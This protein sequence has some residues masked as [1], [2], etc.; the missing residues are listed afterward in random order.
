MTSPEL[1]PDS[2]L[3]RM[4]GTIKNA[5][6]GFED[7]GILTLMLDVRYG[8]SLTQCVGG[9]ILSDGLCAPREK[10]DE[11]AGP[12]STTGEWIVRLLR[13]VGVDW[14]HSIADHQMYFLW[15]TAAWWNMNPA[16]IENLPGTAGERFMFDEIGR[17]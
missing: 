1:D 2:G 14:W 12:L 4:V 15:R 5:R 11:G 7:H 10:R 9:F 8:E 6:L 3:Y 16:G 13:A 17:P